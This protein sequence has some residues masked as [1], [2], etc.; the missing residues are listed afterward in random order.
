MHGTCENSDA[1]KRSG[2][3]ETRREIMIRIL[4]V[5]FAGSVV[6]FLFLDIFRFDHF[7]VPYGENK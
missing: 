1:H 4:S 7:H 5:I 2:R 3:L 6:I